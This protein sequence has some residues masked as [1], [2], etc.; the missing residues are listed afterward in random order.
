M[1]SMTTHAGDAGLGGHSQPVSPRAACEPRSAPSV[2]E[3]VNNTLTAKALQN[4]ATERAGDLRQAVRDR[5]ASSDVR[6]CEEGLRNLVLLA[7]GL[8]RGPWG[9]RR[10]TREA[11]RLSVDS[12]CGRA[13]PPGTSPSGAEVEMATRGRLPRCPGFPEAAWNTHGWPLPGRRVPAPGAAPRT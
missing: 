7:Y 8:A 2:S 9:R 12:G 1:N 4:L 11:P 5:V 10:L 6:E 3:T 13:R